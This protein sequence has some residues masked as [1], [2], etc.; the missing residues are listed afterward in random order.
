MR[1]MGGVTKALV[2]GASK[3][4]SQEITMKVLLNRWIVRL[5][6]LL[7]GLGP[8]AAIELLLPGGSVIAL[9][10]WLYRHRANIGARTLAAGALPPPAAAMSTVASARAAAVISE[11]IGIPSP[12]SLPPFVGSVLIYARAVPGREG[13]HAA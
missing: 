4:G 2:D 11:S 13:T 8:Y 6:G 5:P 7:R 10:V 9:L 12:L 3:S 1:H